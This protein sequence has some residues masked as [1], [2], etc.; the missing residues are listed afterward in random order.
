MSIFPPAAVF[1]DSLWCP[2][3]WLTWFSATVGRQVL[4]AASGSCVGGA[5][6]WRARCIM[7]GALGSGSGRQ[8]AGLSFPL[9]KTGLSRYCSQKV[10]NVTHFNVNSGQWLIDSLFREPIKWSSWFWEHLRDWIFVRI[11]LPSFLFSFFDAAYRIL[12]P[13]PRLELVP[14]ALEA[15]SLNHWTTRAVPRIFL[16]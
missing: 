11:F 9:C 14:L 16:S 10:E 3:G 2:S 6:M 5:W 8:G 15:Q 1:I 13:R 4:G 7:T 12:V